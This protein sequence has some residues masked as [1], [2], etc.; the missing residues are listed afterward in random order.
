LDFARAVEAGERKEPRPVAVPAVDEI[1]YAPLDAA[2]AGVGAV[3]L[4]VID[5]ATEAPVE[6]ARLALYGTGH[7]AERVARFATTDA[8]GRVA[9][10]GVAAGPWLTLEVEGH[11]DLRAVRADVDVISGGTLDLGDVRLGQRWDLDVHVQDVLGRPVEGADLFAQAIDAADARLVQGR[12]A[13]YARNWPRDTGAAAARTNAEGRAR[14]PPLAAGAWLVTARSAG[15]VDARGVVELDGSVAPSPLALILQEGRSL[16]GVVVDARGAPVAGARVWLHGT[17]PSPW[18][19]SKDLPYGDVTA[20]DGRFQVVFPRDLQP[21]SLFA[22]APPFSAAWIAVDGTGNDVR[23]VLRDGVPLDVE[24]RSAEDGHA[25]ADAFVRVRIHVADDA[26]LA[27]M[28][29][30]SGNVWSQ[31][32]R[33]DPAGRVSMVVP[34]GKLAR[35][36]VWS[37]G[38]TLGRGP[39]D[40]DLAP[41]EEADR[42]VHRLEAPLEVEAGKPVKIRAAVP[43]DARFAIDGRVVDVSGAPVEG[44]TV[45]KTGEEGTDRDLVA[46][47]DALGRFRITA[48]MDPREGPRSKAFLQARAPGWTELRSE[49]ALEGTGTTMRRCTLVVVPT[50]TV[51]GTV[52]DDTRRPVPFA[53]VTHEVRPDTAS[54]PFLPSDGLELTTRAD[55]AGRFT[56][57]GVPAVDALGKLRL[58]SVVE[59]HAPGHLPTTS[60]RFEMRGGTTIDVGTITLPRGGA[61]RG[62]VLDAD[63]RPASGA[64]VILANRNPGSRL[65]AGGSPATHGLVAATYTDAQGRFELRGTE[66]GPLILDVAPRHLREMGARRDVVLRAGTAPPELALKLE[67]AGT[68]EGVVVMPPGHWKL[69]HVLLFPA[70]AGPAGRPRTPILGENTDHEGRFSFAH[71]PLGPARLEIDVANYEGDPNRQSGLVQRL[72]IA[73]TPS[74]PLRLMVRPQPEG[75]SLLDE[76]VKASIRQEDDPRGLHPASRERLPAR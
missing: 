3:R 13:W 25:L 47:S 58:P 57:V 7:A 38:Y 64:S 66:D 63:G 45:Q 6:G 28:D 1:R 10:D 73:R 19:D 76:L 4:R 44:V 27:G 2:R 71:L 56:L 20:T 35:V 51:R 41:W 52:V 50:V 61:V 24:A 70:D 36:S 55:A 34:P 23:V 72:V 43:R 69:C 68:L 48:S 18:P 5:G 65:T 75:W 67:P 54:S 30:N 9:L 22:V 49:V 60:G 15:K 53:S 14:L 11:K 8:E 40:L 21:T 59:A 33:T 16:A 12:L 26:G 31:S 32:A 29:S 46:I 17:F 39:N 37:R 74:P 62:Q 42:P